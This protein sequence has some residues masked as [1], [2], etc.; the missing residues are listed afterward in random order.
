M[1]WFFVMVDEI[2]LFG[3]DVDFS[4]LISGKGLNNF[5]ISIIQNGF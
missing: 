4:W 5:R 3:F 2:E 1:F